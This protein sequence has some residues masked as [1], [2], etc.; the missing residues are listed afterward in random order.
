M[1]FAALGAVLLVTL[2][3]FGCGA[4]ENVRS[5]LG[6]RSPA[7]R[8]VAEAGPTATPTVARPTVAPSDRIRS[9]DDLP[10]EPGQAFEAEI[11]EE[12][13]NRLLRD[14]S[15]VRDGVT[16]SEPRVTL[17]EGAMLL[18]VNL[19][20]EETG[21]SVEVT[22]RGRPQVVDGD[23]YVQVENVSLGDSVGGLARVLLQGVIDQALK[24]VDDAGIPVS[25]DALEAVEVLAIRVEPSLLIVSGVTR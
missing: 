17:A 9:L 14:Q 18:S 3:C 22:A 20:H 24:Q 11:P 15:M 1:V 8:G 10:A 2:G 6:S 4:V 23:L 5:L 16:I 7:A 19:A 25:L 21:V 12:D 13:L